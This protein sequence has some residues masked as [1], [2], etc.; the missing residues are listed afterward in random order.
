[1]LQTC[2]ILKC[3]SSDFVAIIKCNESRSDYKIRVPKMQIKSVLINILYAV[4]GDL[5]MANCRK[6]C[7][8]WGSKGLVWRAKLTDE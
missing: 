8:R 4:S 1:M 5:I 7:P 6:D 3:N 2:A